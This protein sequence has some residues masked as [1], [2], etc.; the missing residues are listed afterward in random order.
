MSKTG[1]RAVP[2]YHARK[3]WPRDANGNVVHPRPPP[4]P[5]FKRPRAAAQ[6]IGLVTAYANSR[7]DPLEVLSMLAG[8]TTFRV[9]G[10]GG[11][12]TVGKDDLAHCLGF[13]KD[14]LAQCLAL[15][16]ATHSDGEWS[17]VLALAYP[18]LLSEL[19]STPDTSHLVRGKK[20]HRVRI[21]L[22]DAFIEC[23]C[24]GKLPPVRDRAKA[25][26]MRWGDYLT[27]LDEAKGFLKTWA[28]VGAHVAVRALYGGE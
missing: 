13:V 25:A 8:G 10:A 20:R 16:V 7:R 5:D 22:R 18:K 26:K 1:R 2:C 12:R 24:T 15:A 11:G 23:T 17:E 6:G 9:P 14:R 28:L 4:A 19:V 27:L 3:T 21:V